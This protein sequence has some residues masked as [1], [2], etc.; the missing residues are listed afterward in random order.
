VCILLSFTKIVFPQKKIN[1]QD[2]Q[3]YSEHIKLNIK[4]KTFKDTVIQFRNYVENIYDKRIICHDQIQKTEI[5]KVIWE[6]PYIE[7]YLKFQ[8]KLNKFSFIF[9]RIDRQKQ[10]IASFY[11]CDC[12]TKEAIEME[13]FKIKKNKIIGINILPCCQDLFVPIEEFNNPKD[14]I[15][16]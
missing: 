12:K 4:E 10:I 11:L 15:E 7:T 3:C 2:D 8:M 16:M 5:E 1:V 13:R 14:F 9:Y 6:C